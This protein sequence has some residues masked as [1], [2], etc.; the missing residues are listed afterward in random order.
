MGGWVRVRAGVCVCWLADLQ[1]CYLCGGVL[2]FVCTCAA[3]TLV[4]VFLFRL[5][6]G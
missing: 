2:G 5:F 1:A 4:H 3:V 6:V